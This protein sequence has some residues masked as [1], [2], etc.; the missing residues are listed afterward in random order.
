[1][2]GDELSAEQ[3]A[4]IARVAA[5][6]VREADRVGLDWEA[7]QERMRA[8]TREQVQVSEDGATAEVTIELDLTLLLETLRQLPDDAG[9]ERFLAAY[10]ATGAGDTPPAASRD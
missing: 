9:T 5:E 7:A 2:P 6:V 3:E 8:L 1:M 4:E 10:A